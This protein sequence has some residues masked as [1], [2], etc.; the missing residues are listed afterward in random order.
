[1]VRLSRRTPSANPSPEDILEHLQVLLKS[2]AFRGARRHRRLLRYLVDHMLKDTNDHLKETTLALDV[3][4]RSPAD[5]DSNHDTIVRVEA[6]RLRDRL[7]RYYKGDGATATIELRL[8]IGS[9]ALR[10]T[11][12]VGRIVNNP[13]S[14]G[15]LI[16]RG[17]YLIRVGDAQSLRK[18]LQRFEEA[19]VLEGKN[20][21]AFLGVARAK[22]ALV[23][24]TYDPPLPGVMHARTALQRSLEIEADNPEALVLLGSVLH[25]YD[26]DWPAGLKAFR[27]AARIA[28]ELPFVH[29]GLG[30]HL[31]CAGALSDAEGELEIARRL[32]PYYL[33]SRMHMSLLRIAQRNWYQAEQELEAILDLSPQNLPARATQAAVLLYAGRA[34]E[35]LVRY[36]AIDKEVADHP[37]GLV[38]CAQALALLGR[39]G[40]AQRL[41]DEL[42]S[43]FVARYISPYQRALIDIRLGDLDSALRWLQRAAAE[44][45]G[46][47]I[48]TGNEPAFETLASR[49]AFQVLAQRV[50]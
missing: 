43:R 20:A 41:R 11:R 50:R 1:M 8:P 23:S 32:D 47:F 6:R 24:D 15:E 38:G 28:P 39:I 42:D 33:N 49:P 12:R 19:V 26:H 25:R 45:D 4:D 2:D 35:A 18:A 7:E 34:D 14:A 44:R 5:F 40:E 30:F 3:F 17:A 36:E 21:M 22:L 48:F 29:T 16:E 13:K 9:Y 46:N 27:R 37:I 10:A 31:M